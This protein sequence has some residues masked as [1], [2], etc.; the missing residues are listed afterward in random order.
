MN[1]PAHIVRHAAAQD[2]GV[3]HSGYFPRVRPP[4][5]PARSALLAAC[6]PPPPPPA[7]I[8]ILTRP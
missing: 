8:L 7:M 6:A 5:A 4:R 1:L 3:F 2:A